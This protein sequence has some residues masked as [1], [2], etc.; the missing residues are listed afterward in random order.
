[1]KSV[2]IL[3]NG[4]SLPYDLVNYAI[5]ETKKSPSQIHA[6]FLKGTHEPPKGY[7]YPSDLRTIESSVSDKD[8]VHEDEVILSHSIELVRKL[9]EDE[10]LIF[11]STVKTNA[12]VSEV[13]EICN[14]ADLVLVDK[15]F[16]EMSLLSDNKIS[17]KELQKKI[18]SLLAL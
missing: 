16:D 6:V 13:C 11:S 1:M 5:E 8:A 4:I 3:I 10:N 17:L 18:P 7:L 2:Y 14:N 15:N 9:I 12:S